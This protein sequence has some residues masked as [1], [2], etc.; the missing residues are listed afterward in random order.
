MD[1]MGY[2]F[3]SFEGTEGVGK[4]SQIDAVEKFLQQ[5]G[6]SYIRTREPGGSP[7][8]EKLRALLIDPACLMSE[9][10]ELLLMFAARSDH[11][12]QVISPAL[13]QGKIV[14]CDR[15]IDS[16]IAYQGFGRWHGDMQGLAKI[17]S[18]IDN[19]VPVIPDKTIW[20]D[21]PIEVGMQRAVKRGSL[22]RFEQEKY[23][24]FSRVRM[25]YEYC[26]KQSPTR[27]CRIDASGTREDVS[28]LIKNALSF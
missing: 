16:S 2:K 21:L 23:D 10:S 14:L 13:A 11:I 15:F 27:F 1:K 26:A 7:F 12:N 9:E 24:F 5:Q 22:D 3:I 25:G 6:I 8:A 17:Q 28:L 4:T 20:L 18:L 19:F